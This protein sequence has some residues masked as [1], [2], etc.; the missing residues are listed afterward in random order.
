MRETASPNP[1]DVGSFQVPNPWSLV[2]HELARLKVSG[3]A[4]RPGAHEAAVSAAWW[5]CTGAWGAW[6]A[7]TPRG[8][9][10]GAVGTSP[11]GT[12]S[13]DALRTRAR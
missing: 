9:R 2:C 1:E 4:P 10:M 11:T 3:M 6:G 13:R 8:A 7:W 5:R 12:R